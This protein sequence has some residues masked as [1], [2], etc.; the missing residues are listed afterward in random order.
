M[1]SVYKR[2][3]TWWGRAQRKGQEF[4]KSL[5]TGD[6][7]TA[8]KRL[9]TW[10]KDLEATGWGDR[11]RLSFAD[12]ARG[13]IVNYLPT[14]KPTSATRYGVSLKWLSDKFGTSML[15][16]IGREELSGF[17][18]W[19]RALGAA[20]PTIRRD[21]ACL[22]SIFSYCED[23]DWIEDNRNPVPGFLKRRARRGLVE[24]PG[25][26]RYL[27]QAEED[28]LLAKCGP[29]TR[30][31]VCVAIDT[32]LRR[33][34]Q[35]T[36]TWPQVDLKRGMIE[37]TIDTKGKRKRWV[38]LPPRS[39]QILAQRRQDNLRSF[40]VFAHGEN[41]EPYV[42]FDNGFR[43]AMKRAG[44]PYASWHDLRRTAGCRWLQRDKRSMEEVAKLLGHASVTTT[45]K[46]YAFLEEETVAQ[47]VSSRT[48]SG[49]RMNGQK[50][51]S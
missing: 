17:E 42:T 29:L 5:E 47:E 49:T 51:R 10:V 18:S 41:G 2:G 8:L 38:P 21:L 1:A 23:Q 31:A 33:T 36:L 45:E 22:S 4:R 19:R 44:L 15:D 27:S 14:L 11:A 9:D 46:H 3:K 39:A 13:F 32:G 48:N 26:R 28:A 34:E 6:R 40:Y 25:K 12:A 37:T 24:S 16:E 43:A 35:L 7:P 20:S 50:N 30:D